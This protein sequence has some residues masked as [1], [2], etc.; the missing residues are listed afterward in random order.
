MS[1]YEVLLW[2]RWALGKK[3][4]RYLKNKMLNEETQGFYSFNVAG[5]S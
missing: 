5:V 2:P 3:L 4:G 1:I